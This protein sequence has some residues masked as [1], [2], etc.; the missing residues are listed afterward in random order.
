M[1]SNC[2][3]CMAICGTV[4]KPKDPEKCAGYIL[5]T[6]GN[7]FRGAS[8]EIIAEFI[9]STA[10]AS[11]TGCMTNTRKNATAARRST[12][13]QR[14]RHAEPIQRGQLV[15]APGAGAVGRAVKAG[16]I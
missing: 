6:N 15:G 3:G 7:I 1:L 14:R 9:A 16:G 2:K 5:K 4:N 8:D 11:G 12:A 13:T 10:P